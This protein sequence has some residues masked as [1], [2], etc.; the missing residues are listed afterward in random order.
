MVLIDPVF[1]AKAAY[2]LGITN[3]LGLLLVFF[4]CRCLMGSALAKRLWQHGWYRK[5][6]SMHCYY[7]WLFF[8]SVALH[9]VLAIIAYGNP[10]L[11]K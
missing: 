7:W 6:Y 3:L 10:F 4:S 8:V 11:A 5:F 2:V 1:G 9:A